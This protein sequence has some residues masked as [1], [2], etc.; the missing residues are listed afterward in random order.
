MD[1][2]PISPRT[3]WPNLGSPLVAEFGL[4]IDRGIRIACFLPHDNNEQQR[5]SRRR[6]AVARSEHRKKKKRKLLLLPTRSPC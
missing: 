5:G 6:I 4:L 2:P 3:E 1:G